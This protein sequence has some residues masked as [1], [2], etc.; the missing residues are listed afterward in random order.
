MFCDLRFH[1]LAANKII[2]L[3]DHMEEGEA[4]SPIK[5]NYRISINFSEDSV[6]LQMKR[7]GGLLQHPNGCR[8]LILTAAVVAL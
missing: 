4:V 5:F 6:L 7:T 2:D 8:N 1:G 3:T